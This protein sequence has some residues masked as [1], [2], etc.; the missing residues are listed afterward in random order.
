M[1][2]PDMSAP[3]LRL[4]P[5]LDVAALAAIYAR[6]GVVQIPDAF[7]TATA[8]A[9][10]EMLERG[11]DWDLAFQDADGAKALTQAAIA[12]MGEAELRRRLQAMIERTGEGYGFIY[13]SYP[14]IT[15]YLE[16]RD[17]GHAIHQF[18]EFL[19]GEFV[20]FGKAVTGLGQIAKADGQ[21][22]QYRPGDFIGK[23]NDVGSEDSDRLVAY[24]FGFTRR[25]R[26]DW[27]GQLLFHDDAGD[28]TRGLSPRWNTLTLFSVPQ[29]HSVAPVAAYARAPRLSIVGWLRNVGG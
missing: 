26:P 15:A 1:S 12:V 18:T 25:W 17:P 29:S 7:E 16:G 13:R 14:M 21:A 24:T 6:D 27:G 2:A 19:N 11:I 9:L 20:Q 23:H 22:T 10:T 5:R 28:V 8:Q 4:N 3:V